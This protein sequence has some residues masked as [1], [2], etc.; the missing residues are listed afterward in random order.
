MEILKNTESLCPKC[1]RKIPAKLVADEGK[2]K[3]KKECKI[4]GP[5]EDI[6]WNDIEHYRWIIS[7]YENGNGVENPKTSRK[8]GCPFD[9][10]LCNEHKSHTVLGIIDITNRCNLSCPVCFASANS[11]EKIY[12]PTYEQIKEM[13]LSLI[14]N[15]P[16]RC[17][18]FQF[19]GGEPTLRDDLPDLVKLGKDL[20]FLYIMVD[21]N[22]IRISRDFN[23]LKKLKDAGLDSFYLQ[24]DGLDDSIYKKT[25]GIAMLK[26]KIHA[27][28]NCRKVGISVVLVVTLIKGVNDSQ[29]GGIIK[30]AVENSDIIRCVNFQPISFSGNA[31]KM[32]IQKSRITNYD[33]INLVEKQT[34]GKIKAKDF[35]PVTVTVP[36][37]KFVEAVVKNPTTALTCH[38]ICGLGTY[39]VIN[40]RDYKTITE[41]LD[42]KNLLNAVKEGANDLKKEGEISRKFSLAKFKFKARL[43]GNVLKHIHDPERREMI[44]KILKFGQYKDTA[45]FHKRMIM[46]GSM[47]F[48]D[49]WNYDVERVQNCTIHYA[50]PDGRLIPFCSYNN[51]YRKIVEEKFSKVVESNTNRR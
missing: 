25:R 42:V 28:E 50:T 5:F 6:Y 33:F 32:E 31:S 12:E 19:S 49:P 22:G 39:I 23:Y 1:L 46:I 15:L 17:Y 7:F 41:L 47:H 35:Y 10:G 43:F 44:M 8:L 34:N 45:K 2:V 3:I 37:S 24:F 30:F 29:I 11:S 4:H 13:L 18:A 27:I 20:G 21:T 40:G 48:M 14:K 9:C 26:D 38:P 51:I 16:V 36:F